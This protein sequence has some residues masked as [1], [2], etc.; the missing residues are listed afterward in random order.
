MPTLDDVQ[1][2]ILDAIIGKRNSG[3]TST[4]LES[5]TGTGKS[6]V[7]AK[8]IKRGRQEWDGRF[9]F[10]A[11]RRNLIQQAEDKF[12]RWGL[13]TAVEMADRK[14]N[15]ASFFGR[16]D[17]VIGSIDTLKGKRLE[18]WPSDA[19]TD[20]IYDE[21]HGAVSASFRR[22]MD[23]FSGRRFDLG[24]SATPYRADGQP[25][26]PDPFQDC[27][28]VYPLLD[29]ADGRPGAITNGHLA[30]VRLVECGAGVSLKGLRIVKGKNG[31]DYT[32]GE[33]EDRIGAKVEVIANAARRKIA[34]FGLRCVLLFAPGVMSAMA[35]ADAFNAIGISARANYGDHPDRD[36][37]D[38]QFH[39]GEFTLLCGADLY[40]QGYDHPPIDGL[41]MA[42]P[43]QSRGLA[44]QQLGRGTRT[45]PGKECCR[46][47]GFA[48]ESDGKGPVSTLDLFLAPEA[49][50]RTRQIARRLAAVGKDADAMALAKKAEEIRDQEREAERAREDR[51]ARMKLR[52]AAKKRD[53]ACRYRQ[54]DLTRRA[55]A[56][57]QYYG[58][59]ER[60]PAAQ[61]REMCIPGAELMTAAD[62]A[63]AVKHWTERAEAG[64]ATS[65][66]CDRL[67]NLGLGW[68]RAEE[69]SAREAARM[70]DL[71]RGGRGVAC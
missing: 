15:R 40:N 20:L 60:G 71:L 55:V 25:L 58:L 29:Y 61:A 51:K 17:V 22:V 26:I 11:N 41:V 57:P 49:D 62:A 38:R 7:A 65:R 2:E 63:K 46:V 39:D 3:R 13:K 36:M 18:A 70:I 10:L 27:C 19:F 42:R 44:F 50:D 59:A 33:L 34:E 21:C 28:Y 32:Q 12:Q 45:Y 16:A 47:L 54:F 4:L 9:L 6:I 35:F 37:I 68:D 48:W 24:L 53:V 8:Y 23:Y 56:A 64:L 66:Q 30:P 43:T 5:A 67:A 69:L 14:A 31:R 1:A 52:I